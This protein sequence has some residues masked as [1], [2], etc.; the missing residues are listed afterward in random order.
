VRA[1]LGVLRRDMR[2]CGEGH[3]LTEVNLK[4][5]RENSKRVDEKVTEQVGNPLGGT[6]GRRKKR[7]Q[8]TDKTRKNTRG[9]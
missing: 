9:A 3:I 5:V 1:F 2:A 4:G 7:G 8:G 6:E